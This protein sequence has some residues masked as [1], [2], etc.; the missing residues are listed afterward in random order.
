[1]KFDSLGNFQGAFDFGWD[2]TPAIYV[3]GGTYSIVIKDNHY[4]TNGP[5]YIT[6]LNPN[7]ANRMAISE[8]ESRAAK[9]I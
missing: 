4:A 9:W 7:L 3:H 8:Y 2:S 6:Q 5:Y 1:M